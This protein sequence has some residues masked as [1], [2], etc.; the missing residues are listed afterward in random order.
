[1]EALS[2]ARTILEAVPEE[3]F[4]GP[5]KWAM[6]SPHLVGRKVNDKVY[7]VRAEVLCASK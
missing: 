7:R 2:N 4:W 6:L 3:N 5:D 1:L